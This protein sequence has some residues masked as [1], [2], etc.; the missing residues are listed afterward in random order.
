MDDIEKHLS[1]WDESLG[2]A[3]GGVKGGF[4]ACWFPWQLVAQWLGACFLPVAPDTVISVPKAYAEARIAQLFVI[5][6]GGSISIE[7]AVSSQDD[8]LSASR[9]AIGQRSWRGK[10]ANQKVEHAV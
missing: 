9:L 7:K 1:R 3:G 5:T 10:Q 2:D 8:L 6:C 4:A